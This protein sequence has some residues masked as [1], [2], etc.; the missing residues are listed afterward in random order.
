MTVNNDIANNK[1][2][3]NTDDSYWKT[4]FEDETI[5]VDAYKKRLY[6]ARKY[7]NQQKQQANQ[8]LDSIKKEQTSTKI[9][10][11]FDR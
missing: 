5:S 8:R 1:S 9:E 6:M 10:V 11:I 3:E 4:Y 2:E 7:G